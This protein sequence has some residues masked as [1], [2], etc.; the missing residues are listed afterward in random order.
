MPPPIKPREFLAA[1]RTR[2]RDR[3]RL[4][5]PVG[6]RDSHTVSEPTCSPPTLA[7]TDTLERRVEPAEVAQ[8]RLFE[9]TLQAEFVELHHI[10]HRMAGP[11]HG[12]PDLNGHEPARYL[13]RI[14][15]RINEI[16]CLLQ[17]LRGRFPHSWYDGGLPADG[18]NSA[19]S[20]G[21]RTPSA[22]RVVSPFR[23]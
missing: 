19:R 3:G 4:T 10:A 13:L 7:A 1:R 21:R 9:G 15:A 11:L 2:T 20:A 8:A 22:P 5:A 17:A 23:G 14:Q 18:V 16:Q 12:Q 6:S